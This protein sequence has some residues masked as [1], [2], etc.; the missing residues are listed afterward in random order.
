[1]SSGSKVVASFVVVV[2]SYFHQPWSVPPLREK[3]LTHSMHGFSFDSK[4]VGIHAQVNIH[5]DVH[6]HIH[7]DGRAH[8]VLHS[9]CFCKVS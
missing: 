6:V 1:M 9:Y 7:D 4:S 3:N 5:I 8:A 2:G